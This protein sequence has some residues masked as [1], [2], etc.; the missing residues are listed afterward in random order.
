M[1]EKVLTKE[2]KKIKQLEADLK[3]EKQKRVVAENRVKSLIE[4]AKAAYDTNEDLLNQI[5]GASKSNRKLHNIGKQN[6]M[7]FMQVLEQQA[8]QENKNVN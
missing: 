7:Q 4:F 2:Q 5:D 8:Q 6:L 3:V 1:G